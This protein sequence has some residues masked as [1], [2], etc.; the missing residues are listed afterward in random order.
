[1]YDYW[2]W[3]HTFFESY[4]LLILGSQ[5]FTG[6]GAYG[7]GPSPFFSSMFGMTEFVKAF[8]ARWNEKRDE[9]LETVLANIDATYKVIATQM[10]G[11]CTLWHINNYNPAEQVSKLRLWLNDRFDYLDTVID[12]Y[13]ETP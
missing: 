11:D 6:R 13:D 3:G 9:M 10:R 7:S 4:R 5:P 12:G 1:M 2:G 8:K